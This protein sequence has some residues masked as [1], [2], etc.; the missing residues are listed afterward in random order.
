MSPQEQ[1]AKEAEARETAAA[2]KR[3]EEARRLAEANLRRHGV[4]K[5]VQG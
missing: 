2:V 1:A 3:A 4:A 5:A